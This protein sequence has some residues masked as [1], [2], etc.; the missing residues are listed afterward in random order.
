LLVIFPFFGLISNNPTFDRGLISKI[1]KEHKKVITKNQNNPINQKMGYRTNPELSIKESQMAEKHL[2][3]CSKSL[4]TREM[5]IK[6]TLRFHLTPIRMAKI[7]TSGDSTCWRGCG[8]RG[9]LLHCLWDCK[10]LQPLWKSIWRFFRK[11]EPD[12]PEGPA[13]SVYIPKRCSTMPQGHML[14]YVHS[15]LICDSQ[16]LE[17]N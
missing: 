7:K 17:T 14:H 4:V 10:L 6:R 1:Y 8:E 2:K 16:K 12:L 13:I 5:Q 11:L 9:T 15:S 3:K